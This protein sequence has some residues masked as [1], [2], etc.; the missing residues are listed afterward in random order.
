[1]T[2]TPAP[3]PGIAPTGG[4]SHVAGPRVPP[5][6]EDTI[7]ALLARTATRWPDR[8]AAVFRAQGIR[9][10]WAEFAERVDRLAAGL[11]R[12]GFARG[13]RLG[14]WAPNRAEWLLAQF[15]TARVGVILV[16]INPAYRQHELEFALRKTGCRGLILAERFKTSDY[17]GMITAL[18]PE[19][20]AAEPGRLLSAALPQL[21]TV[22][23]CGEA[24]HPGCWRFSDLEGLGQGVGKADLDAITAGLDRNDPINIQFT[25]G[26]TGLPKGATLTHRNIVNNAGFVTAAQGLTE[27]DRICI[28][29]PFYH[30]FGMVMGTL[31][32][33]TKGACMV[34]PGEGFDP[35]ETLATVAQERPTALYGVPTMF[36]AMLEHPRFAEFDLSSL[37]TGI[38][39]GAPCPI[40]VMKRVQ[41]DMHMTG[42]TIAYGMTETSPV[43]FQSHLDTPLDK[44]VASVGRVQPHL[45]VRLVGADG[46]PVAVGE[47]GELQT[48]GYSVMKGYWDEP[49]KTA[50]SIDA[51][52][53]MHTGD[54]GRM[55]PEGY[56]NVTGRLKDLIIRGGENIAPREVEEFLYTHPDVSQ[57]QVFGVPDP[58]FGEIVAAWIVPKPGT[59][60]TEAAI[61]AFCQ[62]Q[63]AHFKV[64]A[65]VRFKPELPMTVTGKPQKFIMREAMIAEL[66]LS[67]PATA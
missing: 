26:T 44:R 6:S 61:R 63:I 13:D 31:G 52:G 4:V 15:G 11:V 42:V 7:P 5:L 27:A 55:D 23:T 24:R 54:L 34:V 67:T 50:E 47:E 20:A 21:T 39:A 49:G 60:P 51:D 28:P 53:W 33:V 45:E 29:V 1:M 3:T 8:P 17:I 40:E 43:S 14:I 57:V 9:W 22:V 10:T 2:E 12:A 56:V 38:M 41:R 30:C 16:N 58:R 37:R 48:R 36:V 35:L 25:S 59:A 65:M 19:L 62:G 66:N 46:Q 64:P 18:V 32:A